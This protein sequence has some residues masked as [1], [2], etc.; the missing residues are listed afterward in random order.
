MRVAFLVHFFPP[1]GGA[2]AQRPASF[3]RYLPASGID[4]VFFSR[5]IAP[6]DR[7]FFDPA[8]PSLLPWIA[9]ARVERSP[10]SSTRAREWE[11][12]TARAVEAEHARRPFA[13]LAATCP[14]FEL[15]PFAVALAHRLGIP[16]LVDL[17]D[18]WALDGV[19]VFA[20]RGALRREQ[21]VMRETLMGARHVVGNTPQAQIALRAFL[22]ATGPTV[23][24]VTNGFETEDFQQFEPKVRG[25]GP[26]RLHFSGHFLAKNLL[27]VAA[28]KERIRILLGGRAERIRA[29]GR[30]PGPLV[31]AVER[32]EQLDPALFARLEVHIAGKQQA[33]AQEIV[34]RSRVASKFQFHGE[35]SHA[36]SLDLLHQAD[37]LFL[38][39][40]GVGVGARSLIV[41]GKSYEYF[42]ARRPIVAALPPGDARDFVN[43]L[44]AGSVADPCDA[45]E[46]CDAIRDA[47]EMELPQLPPAQLRGFSRASIAAQFAQCLRMAGESG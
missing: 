27:G 29:A 21:A 42:A 9:R 33:A 40:H 6:A 1:D 11:R 36:A 4:T 28:W 26:I 30:G 23:S 31:K 32:L 25:D 7:S 12:S 17:R 38:P 13:V 8:D 22:G 24:C 20:H 35:V 47:A 16:A 43:L 19:R 15:A 18:P 46:I 14:P 41:P 39:L 2:G 37:L 10:W 5:A 44:Q 3:A 34:K 45:R